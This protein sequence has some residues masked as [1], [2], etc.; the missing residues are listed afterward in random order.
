M[1][2][3]LYS[4]VRRCSVKRAVLIN[5]DRSGKPPKRIPE[6]SKSTKSNKLKYSKKDCTHLRKFRVQY[7]GNS[8]CMFVEKGNVRNVQ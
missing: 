6:I 5:T 7:A 3:R 1:I 2:W 4:D 8:I